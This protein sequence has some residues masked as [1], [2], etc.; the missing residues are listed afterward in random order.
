MIIKIKG[1]NDNIYKASANDI[2]ALYI[3]LA[4]WLSPLAIWKAY[5]LISEVVRLYKP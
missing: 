5:E 4:F 3:K 2:I 1:F